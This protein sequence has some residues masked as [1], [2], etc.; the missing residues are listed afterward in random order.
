[1]KRPA[2]P[3]WVALLASLPAIGGCSDP[4]TLY[5]SEPMTIELRGAGGAQAACARGSI[6]QSPQTFPL[7]LDTGSPLSARDDATLSVRTERV[8][9]SIWSADATPTERVRF[10]ETVVFVA[11]LGGI[12]LGAGASAE[13]LGGI[14]G[15]DL[16]SKFVLHF[17]F[18]NSTFALEPRL[19]PCSCE[20]STACWS[21]FQ[22]GDSGGQL[23][24]VVDEGQYTFPG[25]RV[26]LDACLEPLAD[27]IPT[28]PCATNDPAGEHAPAYLPSGVDV[29]VALAT[30]FP[31]ILLGTTAFD[32]LRGNGAAAAL[33][34]AAPEELTLPE[35]GGRTLTVARATLGGA[36]RA[37][38]AIVSRERYYGPCAELARSRRQ[39]RFPPEAAITGALENERACLINRA[40]HSRLSIVAGCAARASNGSVCDDTSKDA[41]TAAFVELAAGVQVFVAADTAIPLRAINGDVLPAS[42]ALDDRSGSAA[43]EMILGAGAM[44]AMQLRLDYPAHRVLLRCEDD[45]QCRTYPRFVRQHRGDCASDSLCQ[46]PATMLE[47]GADRIGG[48]CLAR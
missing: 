33:L 5:T 8:P 16:L 24:I 37:A 38:L 11:P 35:L 1:M 41:P 12:G 7:L 6:D 39:R 9:I 40:T 15:G 27:P 32:R 18:P 22:Y 36:E 31:G 4:V 3:L 42:I 10:P 48:R 21:V 46:E 47:L 2:A 19:I 29:K 26:L 43:V 20:L 44:R 13:P 34:A 14:L 28:T 17:D 45:A 23:N 25:T 30:G